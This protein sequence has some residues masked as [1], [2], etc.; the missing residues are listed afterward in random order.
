MFSENTRNLCS[1]D[2]Q[3]YVYLLLQLDLVMCW[4]TQV[5]LV[6]R[7]KTHKRNVLWELDLRDPTLWSHKSSSMEWHPQDVWGEALSQFQCIGKKKKRRKVKVDGWGS[8]AILLKCL[9]LCTRK[10][11]GCGRVLPEYSHT[12]ALYKLWAEQLITDLLNDTR[13]KRCS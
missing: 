2:R 3:G 11:W 4:V 7:N 10:H 9:G 8:A 13:D 12:L 5:V 1:R 6:L